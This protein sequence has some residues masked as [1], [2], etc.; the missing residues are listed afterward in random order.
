M[1]IFF[2]YFFLSEFYKIAVFIWFERYLNVEFILLQSD[3]LLCK[4]LW[5]YMCTFQ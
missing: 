1:I 5:Q 2:Q 4:A 3:I